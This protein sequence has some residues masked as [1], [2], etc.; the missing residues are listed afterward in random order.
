MAGKIICCSVYVSYNYSA[1]TRGVVA[2]CVLIIEFG[3][4]EV[5]AATAAT[6]AARSKHRHFLLRVSRLTRAP[7]RVV[8]AI[9]PPWLP[10]VLLRLVRIRKLPENG[11][12]YGRNERGVRTEGSVRIRI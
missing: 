11:Q 12:N 8:S 1:L 10:V 3:K 6:I 9:L 2:A 7:Y 5:C 4:H